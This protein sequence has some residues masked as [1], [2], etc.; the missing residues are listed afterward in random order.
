MNDP[1]QHNYFAPLAA[2]MANAEPGTGYLVSVF[3]DS[4]CAVY[5]GGYCDCSPE[6]AVRT[7]AEV[8]AEDTRN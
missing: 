7:A 4:W 1:R 3:H 8:L 6:V 5:L 2:L